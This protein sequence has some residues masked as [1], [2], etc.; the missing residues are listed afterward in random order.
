MK[1]AY[2]PGCSADSTARDLYSSTVAVARALGIE[3]IE[4]EG[5]SC[6][7]STMAHQTNPDLS[8]ALAAASLLKVRKMGLDMV[9]SCASCYSRM[10]IANA[11][12]ASSPKTRKAVA[13]ALGEDYDGSVRVRHFL[14]IVL[15]DV[16]L[17]KLRK[18]LKSSLGGMK[19]ASYYGCLL[20]RPPEI[21]G[22]DDPENPLSMDRLIEAMGGESLDWPSKV[23]CCGG[24]LTLTRSD[25]VVGL[26]ASILAMAKDS[27]AECI[28]VACPMC[29]INLD[30]RQSD[31]STVTGRSYNL[32]ILYI[33]QLMGLCLGL[34]A[35]ALGLEKLIVSPR[36]V[37][38]SVVQI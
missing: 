14:E 16:G 8:A 19:V 11:E 36:E 7:G 18:A 30:L 32:P 13:Q 6:C 20:V 2:F 5:W 17:D 27:G 3:M 12:I 33:P 22:F 4:P 21:T 9:V 15:E 34:P 1:Y 29:Q 31:I 37:L 10:K 26:S 38:S 25:R 28:A 35:D 24:S 23:D